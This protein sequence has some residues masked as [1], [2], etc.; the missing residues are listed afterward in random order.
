[1]GGGAGI[2]AGA[3]I[4]IPSA[5]EFGSERGAENGATPTRKDVMVASGL[6]S[7]FV[8]DWNCSDAYYSTC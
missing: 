4:P 3:K 5:W 6:G 2:P 7:L 1:M 8:A